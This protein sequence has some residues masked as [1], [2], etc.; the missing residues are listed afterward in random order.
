MKRR[1]KVRRY[2]V[3]ICAVLLLG[4]VAAGCAPAATPT[5]E[6]IVETVEVPVEVKRTVVEFWTTD[7]EEYRVDIQE[8]VAEAFMAEHPDIEIRVV[9]I[10]E[11][12]I[13]QR[14]ATAQGANRLPDV[15]RM[16]V[17]RVAPFLASGILDADAA[18]RVI[19][20][21]GEDTFFEG[22]LNWVTDPATGK[23]GAVPFDGWLQAIWYRA[24]A[25]KELGLDAP[26]SWDQIKAACEAI[27][28]YGDFL[29]GITLGTDP[30]QNYPQQVFEQFA[31]SN[32]AFPF[33]EEGNVT[34][35]SP[36]MIEALEFYTSLQDCA[37]PGAN[38]WKQAR[39][40]YITGQSGMLFYSTYVMDDLAGLQ[41]GVEPTVAELS[42][43]TGFASTMIGASGDKATY[44]QLVTMGITTGADTDAA[45]EWVKYILEGDAYQKILAIAPHGKLPQRTT[46][47]EEWSKAEIFAT[48]APEVLETIVSGFETAQRWAFVPEY[49][50]V[51]RAV[52]GDMEG[53][54]LGPTAISN[55]IEGT[56]T[57]ETAAVWLQEQ[58]ESLYAERQAEA[59]E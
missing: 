53:R 6:K 27:A 18:T 44:G 8:E 49:D 9:P 7:N 1:E 33:D 21:L 24:D 23:Y 38:Y 3:L 36:E 19:T 51:Q 26:E 43:K 32:G 59:G 39:E 30:T 29:Y 22:P 54:F 20:E 45:V 25:F 28:G 4:L 16:G 17:E 5:P 31:M 11:A 40:Y 56:M 42:A 34:M 2:S 14:V 15:I 52:I 58:V 48:Y 55:I 13:A 50:S 37:A 41:E 10:D 57:P 46:A 47:V 12:T 35:D